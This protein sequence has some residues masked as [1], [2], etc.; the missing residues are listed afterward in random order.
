VTSL[1]VLSLANNCIGS[2]GCSELSQALREPGIALRHLFLDG[3]A[4][5]GDMGVVALAH[6]LAMGKGGGLNL[7][8]LAG[9]GIGDVGAK[10]LG[11]MLATN[12]CLQHLSI[13]QN[14]I[15]DAGADLIFRGLQKN[16]GLTWIDMSRNLI[17]AQGVRLVAVLLSRN[18]LL[19]T[20]VLSDNQLDCT[21]AEYLAAGLQESKALREVS[22]ASRPSTSLAW[23]SPL[24]QLILSGRVCSWTAQDAVLETLVSSKFCELLMPIRVYAFCALPGTQS[25]MGRFRPRWPA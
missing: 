8:S 16:R 13:R 18:A 21:G 1:R 9:C 6:A 7:L 5:L 25:V 22:K 3:N 17:T 24:Y 19:R 20:L 12:T 2:D 15:R 4:G 23:L 11:A 10:A 14:F